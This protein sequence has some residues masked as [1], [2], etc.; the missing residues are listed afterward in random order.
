MY[1]DACRDYDDDNPGIEAAL[2]SAE[3]SLASAMTTLNVQ[4][5]TFDGRLLQ[6][7]DG[8]S[9][10]LDD[11][12]DGV[13]LPSPTAPPGST[14]GQGFSEADRPSVVNQCLLNSLAH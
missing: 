14:L 2:A 4:A 7:L 9:I 8:E 10:K 12:F 3:N 13:F 5:M 1:L 6:R 11:P